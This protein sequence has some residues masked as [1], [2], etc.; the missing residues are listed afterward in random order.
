MAAPCTEYLR[1]KIPFPKVFF[2]CL[3]GTTTKDCIET[4]KHHHTQNVPDKLYE[5]CSLPPLPLPRIWFVHVLDGLTTTKPAKNCSAHEG[6]HASRR[7]PM[8]AAVNCYK[9][10]IAYH[11]VEDLVLDVLD[12]LADDENHG[13]NFSPHSI[14]RGLVNV[15]A[16]PLFS[17]GMRNRNGNGNRNKTRTPGSW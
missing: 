12:G 1:R 9:Y 6:T 14:C 17:A 11:P 2:K 16:R 13:K 8:T 5:Y 15:H 7:G 10:V 3:K 4:R